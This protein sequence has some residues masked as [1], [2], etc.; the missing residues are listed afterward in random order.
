MNL[1]YFAIPQSK[2]NGDRMKNNFSKLTLAANLLFAMALIFSLVDC[3]GGGGS[4]NLPENKYFGKLPQIE[5]TWRAGKDAAKKKMEK[6]DSKDAYDKYKKTEKELTDKYVAD[7]KTYPASISGREIPFSYTD[8]FKA[9]EA[10]QLYE[11]GKVKITTNKDGYCQREIH[12]TAK[13]DFTI[14]GAMNYNKWTAQQINIWDMAEDGRLISLL[15][16]MPYSSLDPA[17]N[18]GSSVKAGTAFTRTIACVNSDKGYAY[19]GGVKFYASG[20]KEPE[21]WKEAEGKK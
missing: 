10:G 9:S 19:F 5:D 3:G 15:G 8:A 13:K 7:T 6:D 12:I 16:T 20:E 17:F 14:A 11:I 2:Y 18:E 4:S 21:R 1:F